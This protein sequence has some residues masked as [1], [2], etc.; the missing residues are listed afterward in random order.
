MLTRL[1]TA[2][3]EFYFS[4][5]SEVKG[6]HCE[7]FL[8]KKR[9]FENK[10]KLYRVT[11]ELKVCVTNNIIINHTSSK[12]LRVAKFSTYLTEILHYYIFFTLHYYILKEKLSVFNLTE[13]LPFY[14]NNRM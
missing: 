12:T 10:S 6:K 9:K 5:R 11:A 3:N 4:Y 14:Q 13:M 8:I 7:V 1:A 2:N